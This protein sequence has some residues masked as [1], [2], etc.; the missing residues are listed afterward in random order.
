MYTHTL[1][2]PSNLAPGADHHHPVITTS[3]CG[4]IIMYNLLL[5]PNSCPLPLTAWSSWAQS[6]L[7]ISCP[8]H[9]RRAHAQPCNNFSLLTLAIFNAV[10]LSFYIHDF[11]KEIQS[12]VFPIH[13]LV[14]IASTHGTH[15]RQ[16]GI[17]YVL[18]MDI[19]I[20]GCFVWYATL[21]LSFFQ[22]TFKMMNPPTKIYL[23]Q[24]NHL[25]YS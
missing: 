5:D 18:K 9:S 2:H 10:D 25:K 3:Q 24:Q 23:E 12:C 15:I 16:Q 21:S 17:L 19:I 14:L 22:I 1:W 7:T 13:V 4:V 20:P 11:I 8:W 6:S